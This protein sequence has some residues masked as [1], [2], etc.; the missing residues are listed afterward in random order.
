M[1]NYRYPLLFSIFLILLSS[2][3]L[4]QRPSSMEVLDQAILQTSV[5]ETLTLIHQNAITSTPSMLPATATQTPTPSDFSTAT[6]TPTVTATF[7][8]PSVYFD[9]NVNCRTGPGTNYSVVVLIK[10]GNSAEIIGSNGIY[11]IVQ[12]ADRAETCWVPAE[13][14]TPEGSYWVVTTMTQPPSPTPVPPN[15]P[16]WK[17]WYYD[18]S[19][20]G[21]STTL[22]MEMEWIDK[23][24]NEDGFRVL[25]DG[26]VI[27]EFPAD[28]T[29]YI[30]HA[31]IGA[32]Q[33]F[34]YQI[35]VFKGSAKA[36]G[37]V[38]TASC[39]D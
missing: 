26:E 25:R 16:G 5:A 13:F 39:D 34:E 12:P 7:S 37:S 9:S 36:T 1:K 14:V 32:G 38:V 10:E 28:S 33:T 6:I 17:K 21:G 30:D 8:T 23:S 19:Y 2:C 3:N 18:C 35:E 24:N 15:A 20:T 11:W 4:P 31:Q 27:A 29:T 22:N